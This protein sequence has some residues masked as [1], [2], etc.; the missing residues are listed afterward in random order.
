MRFSFPHRWSDLQI[1]FPGRDHSQL[2]RATYWFL[3]I[4]IVN[5]GYLLLN[6]LEYWLPYFPV[7]A[8]AMRVKLATLPNISNRQEWPSAY[9]P[10]GGFCAFCIID[11]T[12]NA[13]CRPGGIDRLVQQAWWTGWKKLHGIKWETLDL[14]LGMNLYVWGPASVRRN[15]N[16]TLG[17]SNIEGKLRALQANERLKFKVIGD[18]A[19]VDTDVIV[20]G[21]GRGI[22]AIREPIEWNYKDLKTLWKYLDYRHVL[23]LRQ[24]PVAKFVFVCM[25]LRNAHCSMYGNECAEYFNL[26]PPTFE[27]WISQG[28]QA[29]P[30]PEDII[31]SEL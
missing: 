18:S 16:F 17:E 28:P 9:D 23:K 5:W 6:N 26:A 12:L 24:Q 20:T 13:T 30:I 8:E 3:D 22:A 11:N 2:C 7:C 19:Y 1:Y 21:G 31:W 29:H 14:P 27:E 4:M 15:D 25:L 10:V